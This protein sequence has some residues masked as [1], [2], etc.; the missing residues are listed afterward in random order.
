MANSNKT[1][2]LSYSFPPS[3]QMIKSQKPVTANELANALAEDWVDPS[4]QIYLGAS[5]PELQSPVAALWIG[6]NDSSN[7]LVLLPEQKEIPQSQGTTALDLAIQA[8]NYTLTTPMLKYDPEQQ[9]Q[10]MLRAVK[11]CEAARRFARGFAL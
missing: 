1:H 10:L 7:N 8:L 9:E 6:I 5:Y 4:S 2:T 3:N 11:A